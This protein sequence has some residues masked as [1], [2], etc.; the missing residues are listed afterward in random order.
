MSAMRNLLEL[1]KRRG[2]L[3]PSAEIH[4]GLRGAYDYGPLGVELKRNI[5]DSWYQDQVY[6]RDDVV[7]IDTGIINPAPVFQ[8][9][10][11]L[12][13]FTDDLVDCLLTKERFRPDKAPPLFLEPIP[14]AAASDAAAQSEPSYLEKVTSLIASLG[15]SGSFAPRYILPLKSPDKPTAK[16]WEELLTT[17]IVPGAKVVRQGKWVLLF[18]VN[19]DTSKSDPKAI[20]LQPASPDQTLPIKVPYHGYVEPCSNSPFLTNPR[21][22]N[23]MFKTFVDPIDPI[24]QIIEETIQYQNHQPSNHGGHSTMDARQVRHAVDTSLAGS[25]VYLRPETAQGVFMNYQ[26]VRRAMALEPPFGVAQV[27]KAF[28]NELRVEHAIFRTLEFEQLELEYF[29]PP[30]QALAWFDY[31]KTWRIRWWHAYARQPQCFRFREYERQELAH[32]ASG[33]SDIEFEFPWGWDEVEGIANRGNFDLTQHYLP[34]NNTNGAK[35][36][37]KPSS[38]LLD[39]QELPHCIESS[40]GL[41]RA[42]LAFLVDAFDQVSLDSGSTSSPAAVRTVLRLHPH[43]APIKAAIL[44]LVSKPEFLTTCQKLAQSFRRRRIPV[45]IEA[46]GSKIGKR[47][48]RHD[49]IGTPWCLTVDYETLADGTVTLRDRDTMQ[50]TRIPLQDAPAIIQEKLASAAPQFD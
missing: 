36:P 21:S 17:K 15:S 4:G 25:T 37:G 9:S 6:R 18:P 3:F 1:C 5:L 45:K 42:L 49:E 20:Y 13:N 38:T 50:Q 31:W 48:Y 24:D 43:F 7:G 19:V 39:S 34:S 32:Y 10:G 26:Q 35:H 16:Q 46:Q 40:A 8:A 23:L 2:F 14:S 29:V 22:F 47:Y 28:R 33:C 41:N 27:G 12:A 30:S 11:H 44:P